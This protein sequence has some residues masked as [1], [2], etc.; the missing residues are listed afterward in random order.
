MEGELVTDVT[1][2]PGRGPSEL[3]CLP[4]DVFL[5]KEHDEL[6]KLVSVLTEQSISTH[7]KAKSEKLNLCFHGT[8]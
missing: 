8:I 3:A 1:S 7:L 5:V 6:P 4:G 2:T